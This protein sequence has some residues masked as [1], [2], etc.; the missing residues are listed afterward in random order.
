MTCERFMTSI[1]VRCSNKWMIAGGR[2]VMGRMLI[3]CISVAEG[4]NMQIGCTNVQC[5]RNRGK[6]EQTYQ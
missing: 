3:A 1:W 5:E 2:T 4:G 6:H